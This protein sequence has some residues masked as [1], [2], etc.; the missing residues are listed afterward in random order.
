MGRQSQGSGDAW[1]YQELE[2]GRKFPSL[3]PPEGPQPCPDLDVGLQTSRAVREEVNGCCLKP[4][5]LRFLGT[6]AS[7][8]EC[9][10]EITRLFVKAG[11]RFNLKGR[12]SRAHEI[13]L[14]RPS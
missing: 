3:G 1:S 2:E 5:S 4:P 10:V 7:G 14:K 11:S 9:S 13:S 8:S 12:S 6:A